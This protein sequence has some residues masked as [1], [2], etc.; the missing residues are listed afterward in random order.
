LTSKPGKTAGFDEVYSRF[1]KNSETR[2]KEW[3]LSFFNDILKTDRIPK[4]FKQVK[5]I[6]ILKP[7]KEGTDASHFRPI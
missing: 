6:T 4:L 5:V 7:G 1:I 2:T 3:I